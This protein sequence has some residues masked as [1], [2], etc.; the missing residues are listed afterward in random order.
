MLGSRGST[1]EGDMVT[2]IG[3]L[4]QEQRTDRALARLRDAVIA[5][6]DDAYVIQLAER[7]AKHAAR[8]RQPLAPLPATVEQ[9]ETERLESIARAKATWGWWA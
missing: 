3:R 5:G 1:K 9:S 8:E 4:T 2:L 6:A 7:L